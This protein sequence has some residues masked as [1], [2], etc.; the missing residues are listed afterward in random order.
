MP[1]PSYRLENAAL[2]LIERLEGARPTWMGDDE[3]AR[4]G[5]RRIAEEHIDAL[6]GEREELLG[7]DATAQALRRE[8]LETFLPRYTRLAL[9]HNRDEAAGYHAWRRGDPLARILATAAAFVAAGALLRLIHHPLAIGLFG[10]VLLVPFL[11]ELRR[12]S[13]R[14][15]YR[16]LLQEVVDDM[17]RIQQSLDEAPPRLPG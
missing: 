8:L 4:A 12:W 2:A 14:R 1:P 9:D 10:L 16:A 5:L 11:P 15:R 6:I 17:A 3:A 7:P 13:Y